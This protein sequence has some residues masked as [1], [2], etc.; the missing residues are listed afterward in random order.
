LLLASLGAGAGLLLAPWLYELLF[1]FQPGFTIENSTLQNSLDARVL[2][3]TALTATLSGLLFGLAPAWQ[4]ARA[5]L[6]PALKDGEANVAA[7]ERR[8][9]ARNALVVAQVAL[10]LVMLIGAGLLVRSL[11]SLFAIDP[12]FRTENLLIVPLDLPRAA[13][14]AATD[15]AGKRAV[16]ERYGQYFAQLTE[17]VKALPGVESAATA[18][19]TPLMN[20]IGKSSVVIEGWQ[21]K[22]GEN[23]AIDTSK[24]GPGYHEL[25]GIPFAQGRGFTEHD[26]SGAPGVVIVNETLARTYYPNQNPLGKRLSLGPGQPWLEIIGVTRDYRLHS[27]TET[28]QPHFDLPALQRPYGSSARLVVRTKLDPLAALPMVRKEAVALNAQVAMDAPTTLYDELKNTIAAAR[29]AST[30]TSL[31]GLT[32]LL[33]AGIGLYG[34]MSQA[35]SRRTREI[36]IRMALGAGRSDVLRLMLKQGLLLTGLGLVLG[37]LAALLLTRLIQTLLYGVGTTDPLTFVAVAL[38]LAGV[39]LLAC[40]IPARRAAKVDP[41]VALRY[42]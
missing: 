21:L 9:N 42:E 23:I 15:E 31:F 3:F 12:G 28:P 40:W 33:L 10:S 4:S 20:L 26:N 38:L 27:L 13:Y 39:A 29:M 6:I 30:L 11:Q 1:A 32:A 37:L 19:F 24:V 16:D 2:G 18:S 8:W 7:G 5:D 22:P 34:V 17:R 35:V 14:S 41:M 36:G 25:L